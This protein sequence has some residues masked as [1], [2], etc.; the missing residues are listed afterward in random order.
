[1]AHQ[2]SE[3]GIIFACATCTDFVKKTYCDRYA[4][5]ELSCALCVAYDPEHNGDT[6]EV[7]HRHQCVKCG[8]YYECDWLL[9]V[10]DMREPPLPNYC[11]VCAYWDGVVNG[12]SS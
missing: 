1:M 7:D 12:E 9:A 6:W 4:T 10:D 8:N 5:N 3:C 2:C 11:A